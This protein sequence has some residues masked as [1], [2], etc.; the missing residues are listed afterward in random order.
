[1]NREV[2]LFFQAAC[3][4]GVL[5]LCYDILVVFRK[6]IPHCKWLVAAEDILFWILAGFVLFAGIYR[7]N[8][9]KLRNFLFLG[10]FLGFCLGRATISPLFVSILVKILELPVFLMKKTVKRLL[11]PV[12]RCKIFLKN[13]TLSKRLRQI[14]KK[15]EK[16]K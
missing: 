6:V 3:V 14:E 1:M 12:K 13:N 5:L 16:K 9:G 4:G 2:M 8:E 11:F 15:Q 7:G 10:S